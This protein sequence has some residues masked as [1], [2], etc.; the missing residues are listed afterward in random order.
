MM[1]VPKLLRKP[2]IRV[3]MK[4]KPKTRVLGLPLETLVI[5]AEMRM[6]MVVLERAPVTPK[7]K[8][9]KKKLVPPK[10]AKI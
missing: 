10:S 1:R 4:R 2:L 6:G 3:A 8:N 5:Q 9:T 7:Q